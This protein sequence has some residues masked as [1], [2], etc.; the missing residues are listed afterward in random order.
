MSL[1]PISAVVLAGGRAR[2]M[3]TNKALLAFEGKPLI[4]RIV[5]DLSN[6]CEEVLISSNERELY[7]FLNREILPDLF[8]GAGP[9]AGIHAALTEARYPW[10]FALACDM[11]YW[12]PHLLKRLWGETRTEKY[13]VIC[14]HSEEGPEP[15][16]ALYHRDCLPSVESTLKDRLY[17]MTSFFPHVGVRHLLY[18]EISLDAPEGKCFRNWNTLSDIETAEVSL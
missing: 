9:L 6:V 12:S 16:H 18:E 5:D 8:P 15:L 2:R 7:R 17:K 3:G 4:Q 13:Q 10:L 14:P 11:P 1:L